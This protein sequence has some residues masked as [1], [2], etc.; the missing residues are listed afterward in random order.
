MNQNSFLS[1]MTPATDIYNKGL[2]IPWGILTR[3]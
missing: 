2:F 3:S 1:K